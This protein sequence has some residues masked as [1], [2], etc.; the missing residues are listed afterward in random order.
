MEGNTPSQWKNVGYAAYGVAILFLIRIPFYFIPGLREATAINSPFL[1]ELN[2]LTGVAPHLLLFPVVA[3]LPAP[4]WARAAGYGWLVIDMTTDIMQ[5]SGVAST[6]FLSVRYGGHIS[7]A[8]WIAA[9]AWQIKGAMRVVGL[10]LALDLVIYTFVSPFGPIFLL[11]FLPAL[12][13]LPLWFA[14]VGR[15]LVRNNKDQ[16]V[17]TEIG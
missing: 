2:A 17:L 15:L 6:I 8:V 1:G 10:L 14:L 12:V 7:A 5:L 4:R 11:V 13:L 3:A 16:Q 9:S